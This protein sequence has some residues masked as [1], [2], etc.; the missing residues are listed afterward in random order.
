M[1]FSYKQKGYESEPG[2]LLSVERKEG[3]IVD[4]RTTDVLS[5]ASLIKITSFIYFPVNIVKETRYALIQK[6]NCKNDCYI[7]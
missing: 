1:P 4:E 5:L 7:L 2:G 3:V 6:L